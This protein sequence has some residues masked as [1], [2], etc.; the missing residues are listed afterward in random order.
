MPT[1][2]YECRTCGT[3]FERV[4]HFADAPIT[5]CPMGHHEVHRVLSAPAIIFNAPG[6]YITE[7]RR[8]GK[9]KKD[10]HSPTGESQESEK[11]AT[12]CKVC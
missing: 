3:R 1:Y 9:D 10:G 7:N 5:E 4:Q 8:N 2:E 6:F 11:P 12:T